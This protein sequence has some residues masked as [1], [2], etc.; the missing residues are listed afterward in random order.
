MKKLMFAVAVS[1]SLMAFAEEAAPA[2]AAPAAAAPAAQACTAAG[3]AT[4]CAAK[5]VKKVVDPAVREQ[6]MLEAK[7]KRYNMT[8]EQV[9]KL[10]KDEIKQ[11]EKGIRDKK[12]LEQA[13]EL[14]LTVEAYK[15]MPKDQLQQKRKE[16]RDKKQAARE[17][18]KAEKAAKK[19]AAK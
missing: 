9:K 10:S 11:L 18:A 2:A 13:Q 15:A 6:K 8:V 3:C 1:C 19:A 7:A 16:L 17:K 4:D 14:G 5:K 12:D